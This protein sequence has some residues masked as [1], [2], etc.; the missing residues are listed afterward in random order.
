MISSRQRNANQALDSRKGGWAFFTPQRPKCADCKLL[1]SDNNWLNGA[2]ILS[3]TL[4]EKKV[5]ETLRFSS[6]AKKVS[7]FSS[8]HLPV[9]VVQRSVGGSFEKTMLDDEQ[10]KIARVTDRRSS[11]SKYERLLASRVK[12]MG[13][14]ARD[15]SRI[16]SRKA[17]ESARNARSTAREM[18]ESVKAGVAFESR[19][20]VMSERPQ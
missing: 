8:L 6:L 9:D 20:C 2:R 15:C 12:T 10:E 7:H 16:F 17:F 11:Y 18:R 4:H 19:S 3:C 13:R 14:I 1:T 5:K